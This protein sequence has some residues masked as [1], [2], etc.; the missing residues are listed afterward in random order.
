MVV[1]RIP[2]SVLGNA[3]AVQAA[4]NEYQQ[5]SLERDGLR[6]IYLGTLTWC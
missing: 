5:R 2:Q 6:C 4:S 3:L 1:K